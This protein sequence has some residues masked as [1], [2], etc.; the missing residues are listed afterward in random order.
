M[1]LS[2]MCCFTFVAC[3]MEVISVHVGFWFLFIRLFVFLE[4]KPSPQIN[5]E[6]GIP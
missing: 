4:K 2:F 1:D 3:L 6:A 5:S